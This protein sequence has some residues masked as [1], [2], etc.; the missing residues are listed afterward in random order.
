MASN[1]P[2]IDVITWLD[3]STTYLEHHRGITHALIAAPVIALIPVAILRLIERK[4]IPWLRAL[5]LSLIG[6]IAHFLLDCTNIYGVRMLL[7]FSSEWLRLDITGLIDPWISGLLLLGIIAPA[8][9]RLVSSE[10]GARKST[11][12]GWAVFA[13]AGVAIFDGGRFIA[14][15]RALSMLGSRLYDGMTPVRVAAFPTANPLRWAGWVE[16]TNAF[17]YR[18]V[19]ITGEFDPTTGPVLYKAEPSPAIEAAKQTRPFRVFLE[20][21]SF[22]LWRV[23][24]ASNPEGALWVEAF[25][26]RFGSPANPRFNAAALVDASN[27]VLE[28]TYSFR[29]IPRK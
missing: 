5:G 17:L 12:F 22:T 15:E 3:G 19:D 29:R 6:V 8:I 2:D 21:S 23:T 28:A 11:G 13:L 16:T 25:D 9:S 24:P 18:P 27:R 4:P 20:F 10:I 26:L 14:R 1:V 7:P